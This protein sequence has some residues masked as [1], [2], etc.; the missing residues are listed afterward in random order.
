M[1]E[2]VV[3]A[4]DE[5]LPEERDAETGCTVCE[6]DQVR[7]D[8]SGLPVF[9][10]CKLVAQQIRGAFLE[11]KR[12]GVPI[13]SVVAYRV[14]RSRG[15]VDENGNRQGFSNHSFGVALD[16]N[17]EHNGLYTQCT[18][19]GPH[20]ILSR[21]GIWQPGSDPYSLRKDSEIVRLL[22]ASGLKWGGEI[23]GQQKDFMHFSPSGY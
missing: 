4:Y 22:K 13:K 5:L 21:G 14:G 17:A 9:H 3:R 1:Q 19:F 8:I 7:I 16:I 11:L 6:E 10:V 15:L 20:C 23:A 2:R 12:K 18:T